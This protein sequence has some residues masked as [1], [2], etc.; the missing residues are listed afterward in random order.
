[1][2][3][4]RSS[5]EMILLEIWA[6]IRLRIPR[7]ERGQDLVEYAMLIGFIALIV[8]GVVML[9]GNGLSLLLGEI[10]SEVGP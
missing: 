10:A 8:V 5:G 3:T 2:G 4:D 6:S 7:D 1:M 9:L